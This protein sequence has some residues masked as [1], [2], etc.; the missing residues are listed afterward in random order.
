MDAMDVTASGK[1]KRSAPVIQAN[2]VLDLT[3]S[4]L[5]AMD[6]DDRRLDV[7]DVDR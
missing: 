7:S 5:P 2:P 1:G 3:L 6:T 4:G